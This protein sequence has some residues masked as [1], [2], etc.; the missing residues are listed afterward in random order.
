MELLTNKKKRCKNERKIKKTKKE[1]S[2]FEEM[3]AA[4]EDAVTELLK[5]MEQELQE[6]NNKDGGSK[7]NE[8]RTFK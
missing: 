2:L 5:V 4:F 1:K 6:K 7:N 8:I 3:V